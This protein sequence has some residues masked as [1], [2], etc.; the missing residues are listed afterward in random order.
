[1]KKSLLFL[2]GLIILYSC[3]PD[4]PVELT[5]FGMTKEDSAAIIQVVLDYQQAY[6]KIGRAHV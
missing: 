1:M 5:K 3:A 2:I 6:E 4:K